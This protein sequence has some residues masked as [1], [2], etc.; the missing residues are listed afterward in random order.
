M[1][2]PNVMDFS[3]TG[4]DTELDQWLRPVLAAQDLLGSSLLLL[5]VIGIPD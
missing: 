4:I 5:V 2:G 3:L 1:G